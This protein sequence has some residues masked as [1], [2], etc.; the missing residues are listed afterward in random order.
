VAKMGVDT[1]LQH[2]DK[3]KPE[4]QARV[5]A[6]GGGFVNHELFFNSMGPWGGPYPLGQT[7]EEVDLA[8]AL[9]TA[10]GSVDAFKAEFTK[11]ALSVK[12]SGWAWL[13]YDQQGDQLTVQTT[14]NQDSPGM[15]AGHVPVLALD[16]WEHAYY[17][18]YQNRRAAFVQNFWEVLDW[19]AVGLRLALARGKTV[20]ETHKP[21]SAAARRARR[22]LLPVDQAFKT[23]SPAGPVTDDP[24]V[25]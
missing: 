7:P 10:F 18:K 17:L 2:L 13:V 22:G 19:E 25:A 23:I 6:A 16:V 20:P 14:A 9:T 1:M 5:R 15:V 12:G 21:P 24:S 4:L 8:E 3:L 11:A